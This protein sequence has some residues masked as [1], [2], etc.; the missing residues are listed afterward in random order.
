MRGV[1]IAILL[2]VLPAWLTLRLQGDIR[3]E[4]ERLKYGGAH[5]DRA[6]RD[7]IGQGMAIGLLAG[8]RAVVADFVWI[9]SH[10]NWEKKQWFQQ[11][12]KMQIVTTLQPQSVLFWDAGAW[13]MAWNIGYAERVDTN[14]YTVA[15][16]IKR[17]QL[18]H[19]RARQFLMRG[20][21]NIPNRYELYFKLG[22][23]Y[24]QKY[25]DPCLAA[26]QYRKAASFSNAPTYIARFHARKLA[27]CGKLTEAYEA[28]KNIWFQDHNKVPHLWNVVEREIR[29]IEEELNISDNRRIFPKQ[30]PQPPAS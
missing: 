29:Q 26:E 14:N 19:E 22:W 23:L 2:L 30:T 25:K 9:G 28:W 5:V 20:I 8:F 15:Q 21:Q 18:W 16:G 3:H 12:N 4:R 13:H 11:Y 17:E 1:L 27:E 10:T 6:M 24:D 7:V